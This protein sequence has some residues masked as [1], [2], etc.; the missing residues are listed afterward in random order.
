MTLGEKIEFYRKQKNLSQEQLKDMLSV[1]RETVGIWEKD[2]A[3][4][5]VDN[6][7]KLKEIFGV[8]V[9]VLLSE[10]TEIAQEDNLAEEGPLESFTVTYQKDDIRNFT[11]KANKDRIVL[12]SVFS[13]ALFVIMLAS[14]STSPWLFGMEVG[15]FLLSVVVTVRTILLIKKS[16]RFSEQQTANAV[17]QYDIYKDH[18]RQ[19]VS[20]SGEEITMRKMLF[21]ELS[22]IRRYGN[23][24]VFQYVNHIF[25]VHTT[26]LGDNYFF[27]RSLRARFLEVNQVKKPKQEPKR[28]DGLTVVS[29]LL[30]I[31]SIAS[32]LIAIFV[33]AEISMHEP[34][35]LYQPRV[36]AENLRVALCFL[37]I[38]VGSLVFGII[39]YRKGYAYKKNIVI[40]IIMTVFLLIFGLLAAR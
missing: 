40:G 35:I 20:R 33:A 14:V 23:L 13:L 36:F 9:D 18:I 10:D 6:L 29:V 2:Q 31:F 38:P 26:D 37:P 4:P 34:N 17:F 27:F 21:S 30:F 8:T 25:L 11:M 15:F 7:L 1:S 32:I 12:L 16:I 5:T 28:S 24:I 22:N 3:R 19:T 39:T